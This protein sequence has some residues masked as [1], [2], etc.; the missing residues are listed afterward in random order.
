MCTPVNVGISRDGRICARHTGL[1]PAE[2]GGVSL[3][4]AVKDAFEG[5][6]RALLDSPKSPAA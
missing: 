4:Q 1:R 5:E 3:Q 6:I 2:A